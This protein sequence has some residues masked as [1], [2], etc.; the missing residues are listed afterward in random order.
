[1]VD[2]YIDIF[3]EEDL[4]KTLPT[5]GV[6]RTDTGVL[7]I[8]LE[9]ETIPDIADPLGDAARYIIREGAEKDITGYPKTIDLGDPTGI[10]IFRTPEQKAETSVS[11]AP[12]YRTLSEITDFVGFDI[13]QFLNKPIIPIGDGKKTSIAAYSPTAAL[14]ALGLEF[15]VGEGPGRTFRTMEMEKPIS[16]FQVAELALVGFDAATAGVGGTA[17]AKALYRWLTQTIKKTPEEA[18]TLM[19][20]NPEL[21][22]DA[23][24]GK[25]IDEL[26]DEEYEKLGIGA[27][28][29]PR[30]T[31]VPNKNQS[32][33]ELTYNQ[34]PIEFLENLAGTANIR[35]DPKMLKRFADYYNDYMYALRP[36]DTSKRTVS[37]SGDRIKQ[38]KEFL[39]EDKADEIIQAASDEGLIKIRDTGGLKTVK[40]EG[41]EF[42][43]QNYRTM[44]VDELLDIMQQTPEN[45]FFTNSVGERLTFKTPQALNEHALRLGLKRKDVSSRLVTK[46]IIP[47]KEKFEE[48]ISS[49]NLDTENLAVMRETFR[50]AV[51]DV[52]GRTKDTMAKDKFS[53]FLNTRIQAYNNLDDAQFTVPT[54]SEAVAFT[55]SGTSMRDT[56]FSY[57]R[58]N[59]TSID[60]IIANNANFKRDKGTLYKFLDFARASSKDSRLPKEGK[61]DDFMKAFDADIQTL[62]DPSSTL[63]AHYNF[64]KDYDAVRETIGDLVNPYLNRIYLAP[65]TKKTGVVRSL[66]ERV[67]DARNSV[68]IA[69]KYENLQS[70]RITQDTMTI[71]GKPVST[72]EGSGVVPGSY[73]LD[74][75]IDNAI[76][77]PRLEQKLRKAIKNGNEAEIAS[78]DQELKG[79]GAKVTYDGVT[80]GDYRPL[81][82]KLQDELAKIEMLPEAQKAKV[83]QERGITQQMLDDVNQ[84]ID[85]LND[86]AKDIGVRHMSYGGMVEDDLDIFETSSQT[87]PEGR[88]VGMEDIDIFEEARKQGYEEVEVANLMVPFFKM[89]GKAPPNV[90]APIP[91]PKP[92]LANQ[93]KKQAES[94][95]VQKEK[96][97]MEDIFD[98][99]PESTIRGEMTTDVALP[100]IQT[101]PLTNQPMTSVFYSDIERALGKAD[102]PKQ[103]L[104]KEEVF[105]YFSKNN[106][107]RSEEVDYRIPEILKLFPEGEP[108]PTSALLAQ[109]RQAPIKGLRVHA[110]GYGSEIINPQGKV[111]VAYSGY[112][113]PG[114]ITDTARERVLMLP[115]KS[116]A[117]DTGEL[118]RAFRGEGAAGNR[119]QFG[120]SDDMYVIGWSRLTDRYGKIPQKVEG[121]TT[122]VN[123][124]KLKTIR[125]KNNNTLNGLYAETKSKLSRLA[126]QRDFN[127]A[128]IDEIM[129]EFGDT[130][131]PTVVAKYADQIDQVS[132][133]LVDQMDELVVKNRE[134]TEQISKAETPSAEGVVRVTFA[135]EIQSDLMQEAAKR[136][137]FLAG[138]LRRMQDQGKSIDDLHEY[139]DLNK[140]IMQFYKENESIFR[141][142]TKTA[143]EVDIMRQQ[144]TKMD[145]EVDNI[146][147]KY[148]TTREISDK[149][150]TRLGEMLQT[151]LDNLLNKVMTIDADTMSKLFPNLPFKNRNEWADAV[152]KKDL[153]EAAY[154]KFVLKDPNAADYYAVTPDTYVNKRWQFEGDTST[155]QAVRNNDKK[156]I[157]DHFQETG[158]LKDSKYKGIGTSEFYGGPSAKAP[159]R[160]NVI[161][162]NK[163]IKE[164]VRDASGEI[165]KKDGKTVMKTTGYQK[166]KDFKG[167][168]DINEA[169]N[170]ADVSN[171]GMDVKYE[172][173]KEQPHYTSVLEKILATQAKQNN[174]EFI[175]LPVQLKE[176]S[177][178]VYKITDQNG[179]MVATLSDS[180]QAMRLKDSN[181]NYQIQPL[182]VPD[183][184]A[185]EPVFAIKI[186]KEMLEPYVTHKAQGGLVEDIDIFEVA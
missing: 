64:F 63:S 93:T 146:V 186:T 84:A 12:A 5:P 1:M 183:E 133:G 99:T 46:K 105:D 128:D 161:D 110:T 134:L 10:G 73:Y 28:V 184:G 112:K 86:K 94:L 173:V 149:D 35:K 96:S 24:V 114:H 119:H 153:Y 80:Y 8:N 137:K 58:N 9:P 165:V 155:P 20:K 135:D 67:E 2:D 50:E 74:I 139:D 52:T 68:Q 116:I 23:M 167:S 27:A 179:N 42:I 181:P 104:S 32:K 140:Q 71:D 81:E 170:Y 127:Q 162:K 91:T 102:A 143:A 4:V 113:E 15:L 154:R 103:F 79:I 90:I 34:K 182:S 185:M 147:N 61:F 25:N 158:N 19:T 56:F 151:N 49:R 44:E 87:I 148:I 166:V 26:T 83:M 36:N 17:G 76:K 33:F 108:I 180:D 37:R 85:L 65:K 95:A 101:T 31:S 164:A 109:I 38:F 77:Q 54:K 59:E 111:D 130:F 132:P 82:I 6:Q 29:P 156:E 163:P 138:T 144:L 100:A 53:D 118:P 70:G 120:E 22:D 57:L 178:N 60:D 16:P 160:Y 168:E 51:T 117:G 176:G 21:A 174:S 88:D 115:K 40:A 136:K 106:I 172:V 171:Q 123:T 14:G 159:V 125:T 97:A 72:L 107:K 141:P 13:P 122:K 55:G 152:I 175:T 69:H 66:D 39:G 98:P 142:E 150:M 48:L 131:K 62:K 78:V 75:S 124:R 45:Y 157:L 3:E 47:I 89:F 126:G 92:N 121:P 145:E 177:M 169:Q 11:L 30:K 129:E 43:K 41:D 18:F 7:D